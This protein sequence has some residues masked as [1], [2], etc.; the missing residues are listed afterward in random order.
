MI[1][2]AA[3]LSTFLPAAALACGGLFCNNAQPVNQAAERI[4][5][6]QDGDTV[7]MHVQIAYQGPP[8]DFGWLL[9]TP[10]DVETEVG[11][12]AL[13]SQLDQQFAP[14]F[15]LTQEFDESCAVLAGARGAPSA[16]ENDGAGGQ[17]ADDGV[18]VLSR[19][20]VG[21]YDRVIL[22]ADN[23]MALREWLD[24]N[25][26]QIPEAT[27]EK[28]QPYIDAGAVF[29]ALKMLPGTDAGDIQPL[30]LT[31]TSPAPAVPIV[32]TA[33]AAEPDMGII[34][35]LLGDSRAV[36]KNYAHVRINEAAIDWLSG[37]QNY[38]DVVSQAAD[39]A[40]G[41]AFTTDY[42]GGHAGLAESIRPY[43]ADQLARIAEA[44][45]LRAVYEALDYALDAD[46][47]RVLGAHFEVPEGINP[48]QYF[49]CPDC[50]ADVNWEAEVDGAA[51]AAELE[52]VNPARESLQAN[53]AASP[54]LTRLYTTMSAAEMTEDPVFTRNPDLEE[55]PATRNAVQHL[56]CDDD[57]NVVESYIEVAGLR[58]AVDLESNQIPG[59]IQRQDGATVRG[60]ETVAARV[61][62]QLAEAGPPMVREDRTPELEAEH[63]A[64]FSGGGGGDSGCDCDST[65][66]APAAWI[67]PILL[68]G[69][70]RRR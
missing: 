60:G 1:R 47:V 36:P 46:A 10:R 17:G 41:R 4:L 9:P 22:D 43:P 62:E 37:G 25:E 70:R 21:P 58:V 42:A 67:L 13:F 40:E 55:V 24:T 50:F 7:H 59:T 32:P 15:Q 56:A 29:V 63:N 51:V 6:A 64:D 39:E 2:A 8:Q 26:F 11:T 31:F 34:V 66:G 38:A 54:Y 53:L 49:N 30:H 57:G 33:V 16:A 23:V 19:E 45:T 18:Q 14:R 65:G 12:E 69:L 61:I 35:H 5:F 48:A 20:A 28:L 27:D 52:T 44:G 3:L 68:L